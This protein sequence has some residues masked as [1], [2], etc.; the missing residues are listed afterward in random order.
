MLK[1]TRQ[2][3]LHSLTDRECNR[4]VTRLLCLLDGK[5]L[6]STGRDGLIDVLD[7]STQRWVRAFGANVHKC[8][9]TPLEFSAGLLVSSAS[10]TN[11]WRLDG[12]LLHQVDLGVSWIVGSI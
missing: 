5:T 12:T 6:V 3:H 8:K 9:V 11:I 1:V 2:T 10:A 4:G 7:L